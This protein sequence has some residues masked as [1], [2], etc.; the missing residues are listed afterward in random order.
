MNVGVL[1]YMW[2]IKFFF[3]FWS[4]SYAL[5]NAKL[6]TLLKSKQAVKDI[7]A[8]MVDLC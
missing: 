7:A 1:T 8:A 4:T 2:A 6:L 5:C 3:K